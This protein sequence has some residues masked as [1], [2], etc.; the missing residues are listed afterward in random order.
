[1]ND[2]P[3]LR[4]VNTKQSFATLGRFLQQDGWHPQQLNDRPIYRMGFAGKNGQSVCFA[5][6]LD[7]LEQF[8]FYAVA[9]VNVPKASRQAVAEFIARANYGLRIGNFELDFSDGEVRYKSS[10]DFEG[11]ALTPELIKN[12]IYPAVQTMDCY[13]PGLISV[14]EGK[15]PVEAFFEAIDK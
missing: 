1:M 14:I 8:V 13:L 9:P 3:I 5:Q 2:Q 10:L 11:V 6:I 15:T 4:D 12:A 7:D